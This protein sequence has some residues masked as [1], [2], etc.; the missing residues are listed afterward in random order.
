MAARFTGP[1]LLAGGRTVAVQPDL[2]MVE[3]IVAWVTAGFTEP[4]VHTGSGSFP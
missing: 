2:Q 3:P 4:G 1:V